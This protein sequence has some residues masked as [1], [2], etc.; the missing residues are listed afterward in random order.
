MKLRKL[1]A[2]TVAI[3]LAA[4][5]FGCSSG[6]EKVA[7][8]TANKLLN[9]TA[10]QA[11]DIL[12]AASDTDGDDSALISRCTDKYG[13]VMT[14]DCISAS[15]KTRALL[16]SALLA[17]SLE[18]DVSCTDLKVEKRASDGKIYDFTAALTADSKT[19]ATVNGNMTVENGKVSRLTL[20]VRES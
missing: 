3:M 9:C 11:D 18:S 4:S 8:E 2:V 6:G 13:D 15:I 14:D 17:Q 1:L 16:R 5:L 10:K 12:S 19:V 20:N 7:R